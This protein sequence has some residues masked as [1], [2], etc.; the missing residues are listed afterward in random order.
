MGLAKRLDIAGGEALCSNLGNQ[1]SQSDQGRRTYLL[2]G[3]G[4]A[5]VQ[6]ATFQCYGPLVAEGHLRWEVPVGPVTFGPS[7]ICCNGVS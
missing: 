6:E 4:Q 1:I 5:L 2:L 3:G 7:Q